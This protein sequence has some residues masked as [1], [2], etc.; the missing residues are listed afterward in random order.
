MYVR[1]THVFGS[2]LARK[3]PSLPNLQRPM[4]SQHYPYTSGHAP[5]RSLSLNVKSVFLCATSTSCVLDRAIWRLS[6]GEPRNGVQETPALTIPDLSTRRP[7][8]GAG[9]AMGLT[10]MIYRYLRLQRRRW[11][12]EYGRAYTRDG[13]RGHGRDRDSSPRKGKPRKDKRKRDGGTS[14]CSKL[15]IAALY[16]SVAVILGAHLSGKRPLRI[17]SGDGIGKLNKAASAMHGFGGILG[18]ARSNVN[19]GGIGRVLGAGEGKIDIGNKPLTAAPALPAA[20]FDDGLGSKAGIF[21]GDRHHAP[22]KS[23]ENESTPKQKETNDQSAHAGHMEPHNG[24]GDRVAKES[25]S[26]PATVR[27]NSVSDV[28]SS[29]VASKGVDDVDS[30]GEEDLS[31]GTASE[32]KG[33]DSAGP[34][35]S[36]VAGTSSSSSGTVGSS[37]RSM[38]EDAYTRRC[39]LSGVTEDSLC[40]HTP[41]CV[42]ASSIVYVAETLKCAPYSNLHGIM[43]TL[44]TRRCV[45]VEKDLEHRAEIADPEHKAQDWLKE[46]NRDGKIQWYEGET[47]FLSL[48]S[49]ARSVAHYSQRIFL[50]HHV[51][52]HPERYGIARVSNVV[53]VAEEEVAKK[54]KF[55]KSWHYGLLA[56]I[57]HPSKPVFKY[58]EMKDML[59]ENGSGSTPPGVLR[60]FVPTGLDNLAKGRQVPCFRRAVIPGAIH[61]QYLLTQGRY[62][63]V[64]SHGVAAH[65]QDENAAVASAHKRGKYFDG[66]MLRKQV[67]ASL[68]RD[69]P[70][71]RRR[72]LYLHRAKGRVLSES[73][74]KRLESA[75]QAVSTELGYEY[76][77]VDL[78]GKSFSEQVDA[79]AGA[80]MAVG[81]HGMQLMASLFMP[82]DGALI[83]IFPYKFW[84][85]LYADGCGSGLSYQS[86]SIAQG[87]D[88]V[89]VAKYGGLDACVSSSRECRLWYRSD[90]RP[91]ALGVDDAS[92]VQRMVRE[93]ANSIARAAAAAASGR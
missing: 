87:E 34:P 41:F 43:G 4:P 59:A 64:I 90:D 77:S 3:F 80:A 88:Y 62:P 23:D 38:E 79:V 15:I 2:I 9:R 92:E 67:F 91:L 54:I 89:D 30:V 39:Y 76:E 31:G 11:D 75:L 7:L 74:Q 45:E 60:V 13:D 50:L 85:E 22:S 37:V 14:A 53:I 71:L 19:R 12:R 6:Q 78:A 55:R 29:H 48:S 36:K 68:D 63:G 83:E 84:H 35:A 44:S 49:A 73:G 28:R 24:E 69:E 81:V 66:A 40:V 70:A 46:L 72:V 57:V 8:L 33:G 18:D 32:E 17:L 58:S 16:I 27:Q 21:K 56:A 26:E 51:L 65:T 61:S 86:M 1:Y 82:G 5:I 52:L 47:V 42:R 25:E 10:H 20:P 93:A